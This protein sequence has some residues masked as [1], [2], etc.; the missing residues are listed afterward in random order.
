MNGCQ[1]AGFTALIVSAMNMSTTATLIITMTLLKFADSL[2]PMTSSVVTS[3]M[4]RMAGTLM[5]AATHGPPE[6]RAEQSGTAWVAPSASDTQGPRAGERAAG[7]HM[8]RV[9]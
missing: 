4:M 9:W 7:L 5:R 2:I 6:V 3:A 8:P 1:L